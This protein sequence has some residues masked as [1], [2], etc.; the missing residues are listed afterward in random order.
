MAPSFA[1]VSARERAVSG[2]RTNRL[3]N[4]ACLENAANMAMAGG[5]SVFIAEYHKV[6]ALSMHRHT[7]V[8]MLQNVG[9]KPCLVCVVERSDRKLKLVGEPDERVEIDSFVTM[10]LY[11]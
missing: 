1:F 2:M 6:S 5:C 4:R 8:S 7:T 11:L 9:D 10:R 3:Q